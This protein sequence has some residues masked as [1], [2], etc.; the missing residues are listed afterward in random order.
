MLDEK[1]MQQEQR[2]LVNTDDGFKKIIITKDVIA[3]LYNEEG[4]LVM[5]VIDFLLNPDNMDL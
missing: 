5:S 3:P 4:V 1:K 2:P